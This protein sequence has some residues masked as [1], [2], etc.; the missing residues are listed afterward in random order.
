MPEIEVLFGFRMPKGLFGSA[1]NLRMIQVTGAG[2][3]SILPADDL[4]ED[5]LICNASGAH[6]PHM[7]EF[8]IAMMMGLVYN[9]PTMQRQQHQREW[10]TVWPRQTIDGGTLCILGLGTIGASV[11]RR[12]AALGMRVV[13]TRRSG[14]PVE[15]VDRVVTM[16]EQREVISGADVLVVITPLTDETEGLVGSEELGALAPGAV[17]VDV[18]RGGVVS[19][20]AVTEALGNGQLSAAAVDVFATEPLPPG[21]PAWDVE[22]LLVTPHTAGW[23]HDYFDRIVQQFAVNLDDLEAGRSPT[24]LV[25]RA[26]GY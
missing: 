12:A 14:G 11:A 19:L 5:V 7:P 26:Q 18:S 22:G 4:A 1:Q 13:G 24:S 9:M 21:D 8:V 17:L 6:E 2:V 10:K 16:A 20:D 3:D 15:G 23:S 25:D